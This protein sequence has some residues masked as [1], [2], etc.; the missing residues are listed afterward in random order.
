MSNYPYNIS[1]SLLML[2]KRERD[3]VGLTHETGF[4]YFG[5]T[6]GATVVGTK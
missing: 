2:F 3:C 6:F 4:T 1:N 5:T